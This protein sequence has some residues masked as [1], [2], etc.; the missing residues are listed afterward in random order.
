MT[1]IK[2]HKYLNR[3]SVTILF[4]VFIPAIILAFFIWHR[5]YKELKNSNEVYYDQVIHSFA[6]DFEDRLSVLQ[7]HAISIVADSKQVKSV[8]HEGLKNAQAH[9]FWYYRAVLEMQELY[10]QNHASFC[11]VY[12]YGT[13][14]LVSSSG[15]YPSRY[16]LYS[17]D[18]RDPNHKAWAFFSEEKYVPGS[19]IFSSTYT[20][21]EKNAYV[22]AGYCTEL[23]K[24][25]DKVMIYYALSRDDY[26]QLQT[27]VYEQS[28]I[29]F[30]IL[31]S[32]REDV[33]MFIGSSASDGTAYRCG[34]K[35][36]PLTY[37][38]R[39]TDNALAVNTGIFYK[40]TWVILIILTVILA[41]TCAAS[42]II[43]Y[44]PVFNITTELGKPDPKTDEFGSIRNAMGERNAKIMEQ[45]NLI[46][47]LLL[48]HLIHGVPISQ[49][50]M[51]RLG[52]DQH[53]D[54]Y[55]VF[56]LDG[57]VLPASESEKLAE[58]VERTLSARLFCT[59]WQ[60]ETKSILILFQQGQDSAEAE[61]LL[62]DWLLCHG[63]E[64]C[65]LIPGS[66][67]SK[68]DDIRDSFLF[69]LE[70]LNAKAQNAS[71]VKEEIS[72]LADRD[73]Q[74]SQ[75]EKQ[76]LEYLETCFRDPDLSQV[77]VADTFRISTYTLSRLFKNQVGIGF[78]EYVN[79]RRLEY[80]KDLLL[81][82][83]LSIREISQQSG[84]ASESYFGR[85]FK[86]TYG[87][88]PS[89]FREQ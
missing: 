50:V 26:A 41:V 60:G 44:R 6:G 89:A 54:H 72:S 37:E 2:T 66:T 9:P 87:T 48:K 21:P 38:I 40:D 4:L 32:G 8:F 62:R 77:K 25:R 3:V 83:S 64:E 67:V 86:A 28:G 68:L 52:V 46:L 69:C 17:L 73:K 80:A 45:E 36:L 63:R 57:Y 74:Q 79:S 43:V 30:R 12:Y 23:G 31:D 16:F 88:S 65:C 75:L 58:K 78:A 11:G 22:L 29:N 81:T 70:R 56:L 27:V 51:S 84:Y 53:M 59:D 14:R 82:T 19:W 39:V 47:D 15:A 5:A 71:T 49:K 7:E 33:L 24:N 55:C 20:E 35:L 85:I 10:P 18:I 42:V 13:D 34:S 1:I 61:A 76:I